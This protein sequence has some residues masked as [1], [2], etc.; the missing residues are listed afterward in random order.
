MYDNYVEPTKEFSDFII[1]K[2]VKNT[3][4]MEQLIAKITA[5]DKERKQ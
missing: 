2:G 5:M 4:A 1:E 3:V